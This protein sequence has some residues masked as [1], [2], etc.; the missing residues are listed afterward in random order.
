[1][2]LPATEA[3]GAGKTRS[4]CAHCEHKPPGEKIATICENESHTKCAQ[5]SNEIGAHS[6]RQQSD[7]RVQIS[8]KLKS[9]LADMMLVEWKT[10]ANSVHH[11][12]T[13]WEISVDLCVHDQ[14]QDP[15]ASNKSPLCR[16]ILMTMQ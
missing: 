13:V 14:W 16:Q 15:G 4:V 1:M 8:I 12:N 7:A 9:I 3:I 2:Q 5:Q 6:E 10:H 11:Q